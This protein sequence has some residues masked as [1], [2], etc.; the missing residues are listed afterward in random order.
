MTFPV[1]FS[2]SRVF[3]HASLLMEFWELLSIL[4]V[5]TLAIESSGWEV[6]TPAEAAEEVEAELHPDQIDLEA[7]EVPGSDDLPNLPLEETPAGTTTQL[8]PQT[9]VPASTE[10]A[11]DLDQIPSEPDQPGDL[12]LNDWEQVHTEPPSDVDQPTDII[13]AATDQAPPDL[14]PGPVEVM[15]VEPLPV[16]IAPPPPPPP[17]FAPIVESFDTVLGSGSVTDNVPRRWRTVAIFTLI[18]VVA[19]LVGLIILMKTGTLHVGMA[20]L[21]AQMVWASAPLCLLE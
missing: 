11:S 7:S 14:E 2:F 6:F 8:A 16:S 12:V 5:A 10:E 1:D 17:Q 21:P 15:P 4:S 19:L 13:E 3:A 9:L 20:A 18:V